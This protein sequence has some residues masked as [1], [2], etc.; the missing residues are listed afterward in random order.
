MRHLKFLFLF[1]LM[2]SIS[3][4]F[5]E[6][7]QI[8]EQKVLKFQNVNSRYERSEELNLI[9]KNTGKNPIFIQR[10]N[11]ATD[12]E[13][14]IFDKTNEQWVELT[15]YRQP[16]IGR[17]ISF[18]K[19]QPDKSFTLSISLKAV[20]SET[21]IR[22]KINGDEYKIVIK[23]FPGIPKDWTQNVKIILVESEVF[24]ID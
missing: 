6:A 21:N 13:I 15:K 24:K 5:I 4:I 19:V 22:R 20:W 7:Q 8:S 17:A 12:L 18:E 10:L 14:F 23:Y 9:L 2:M 1:G 11:E 16:K 3:A